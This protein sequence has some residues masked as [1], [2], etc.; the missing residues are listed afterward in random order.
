MDLSLVI[1]SNIQHLMEHAHITQNEIAD[2]LGLSRQTVSKL[3]KGK[4]PFD[5][6]QLEKV[7]S[8]FRLSV[9][10]LLNEKSLKKIK[11]CYRLTS[12]ESSVPEGIEELLTQYIERYRMLSAKVGDT[13]I[14][15]PEQYS[16]FAKVKG[17]KINVI[18]ELGNL[19]DDSYE[20]DAALVDQ[21]R[22]I[23]DEQRKR[24]ELKD[25]GAIE[26]I[27][28]LSKNHIRVVFLDL[29]TSEVSGA[30]VCDQKYG[31]FIIVNANASL[32]V[33]RQ[34]FT[35]AYEYGQILLHRQMYSSYFGEITNDAFSK[36]LN[37]M[38]SKFAAR[39]LCPPT[40]IEQYDDELSKVRNNL[41]QVVSV[42]VK[43]KHKAQISLQAVIT[44]LKDYGYISKSMCDDFFT[45]IKN[46][47]MFATE[48]FP[49]M[50]DNNL[51]E[52]F[53][54]ERNY[55][56]TELVVKSFFYGVISEDDIASLYNCSKDEAHQR[57]SFLVDESQ[58]IA[59][60]F[61]TEA[62]K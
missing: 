19:I 62:Q 16:L 2:Q 18:G 15:I 32:S 41:Q 13:S 10:D 37:S 3:L 22:S 28:A 6:V 5:I 43:I 21:I 59:D 48:P 12:S 56:V 14:F 4:A 40:L 60:L 49:I 27:S 44:S 17:K 33:E 7:A 52:K 31:C 11:L 55:C 38:A 26:L 61:N 20:V 47:E 8:I 42:A 50:E 58:K 45:L 36:C 53:L 24:L 57:Y 39:L 34:L 1:A 46:T 30:S 23:S 35:V 9:E 51:N 25:G 54:N 29:G